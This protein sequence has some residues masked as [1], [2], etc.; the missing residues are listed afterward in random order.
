[1]KNMHLAINVIDQELLPRMPPKPSRIVKKATIQK[2]ARV[3]YEKPTIVDQAKANKHLSDDFEVSK[4]GIVPIQ[5]RLSSREMSHYTLE[6]KI[7][8]LKKASK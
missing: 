2:I 8:D 7:S 4:L 3:T 5:E 1:M 6:Q